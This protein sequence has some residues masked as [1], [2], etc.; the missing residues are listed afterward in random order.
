MNFIRLWTL[1]DFDSL[2]E[3]SAVIFSNLL[4]KALA[5]SFQ[6]VPL[7]AVE[8]FWGP[9]QNTYSNV[10][11]NVLSPLYQGISLKAHIR[12]AYTLHMEDSPD[13]H[14][15]VWPS[16]RE[17]T[18]APDNTIRKWH[19]GEVLMK[20]SQYLDSFRS[21]VECTGTI[22]GEE[23][24]DAPI[25]YNQDMRHVIARARDQVSTS[26]HCL[27][28]ETVSE[29]YPVGDP[30]SKIGIIL[31][32]CPV[33][34]DASKAGA[35]VP[36][37]IRE[38]GFDD[39]ACLLWVADP[40]EHSYTR[41]SQA[42]D[43]SLKVTEALTAFNSSIIQQS[44][45]R[46]VILDRTEASKY[47]I[48]G[49]TAGS[50]RFEM[51]FYCGRV[52]GFL[53]KEDGRLKRVYFVCPSSLVS[54]WA[55]AGPTLQRIGEIFKLT[56]ALTSTSRIRPYFCNS[57]AAVH[58]II[59]TYSEENNGAEKM[60][61]LTL[62]PIL[63]AFLFRKGFRT[64]QDIS[65]LEEI[66]GSLSRG[67]MLLLFTLRRR[68]KAFG[69]ANGNSRPLTQP[70]VPAQRRHV[71]GRGELQMME[72]FYTAAQL[73]QPSS[74]VARTSGYRLHDIALESLGQVDY[75]EVNE[76]GQFAEEKSEAIGVFLTPQ[77]DYL[78]AEV[79]DID[80]NSASDELFPA[81]EGDTE[82]R[83]DAGILHILRSGQQQPPWGRE[84]DMSILNGTEYR[85]SWSIRDG[86]QVHVGPDIAA[87]VLS[88]GAG[89][90]DRFPPKILVKAEVF[91]GKRHPSNWA[92]ES[93]DTD[94]GAK[95]AFLVTHRKTE[96]LRAGGKGN[97][98]KANT[99]MDWLSNC[100]VE[101]IAMRPRRHI[102]AHKSQII[103]PLN[104]PG[105]GTWY[106]DDQ[107]NL[108]KSGG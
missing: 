48:P 55:N 85:G 95:V 69:N 59:R 7:H 84:R 30:T 79:H 58:H 108:V 20:W 9:T 70:S 96:Y 15:Q 74:Q 40:R 17:K 65:R 18:R 37:G 67:L 12:Q 24:F 29:E 41:H 76:V 90:R 6:S 94:P 103:R 46:V 61:D 100:P 49:L 2:D 104:L 91:P 34:V 56:A 44:G 101:I 72:T 63:Q 64:I 25:W 106:T 78:A 42:Y 13:P 36:W 35:Y 105:Q 86:T 16:F 21:A 31:S 28:G 68:S 5:I 57:S 102:N 53:E 50:V 33:R 81:T 75:N 26:T 8:T 98:R 11:L 82:S 83:V 19:K 43:I 92:L 93:L 22:L 87:I 62:T 47:V 66:G 4:E 32:T 1:H 10:G 54:L 51:T 23:I 89:P 39:E 107:G 77:E 3:E 27:T 14:I 71:F 38:S 45:L 52:I 88:L 99:L 97:A 80:I 60:T 73:V